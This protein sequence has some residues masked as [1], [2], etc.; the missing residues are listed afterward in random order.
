MQRLEGN[1]EKKQRFLFI[2]LLMS[3]GGFKEVLWKAW[4]WNGSNGDF[5]SFCSRLEGCASELKCW[6]KKTFGNIA[7]KNRE[8]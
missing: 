5:N 4:V 1:L 6:S 7:L 2:P 8:L 3:N